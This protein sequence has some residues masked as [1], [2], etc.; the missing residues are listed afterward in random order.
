[1][2]KVLSFVGTGDYDTVTYIYAQAGREYRTKLFPIAVCEFFQPDEFLVLITDQAQQKYGGI[3][4]AEMQRRQNVRY[5][6]VPIPEGKSEEEV[7]RLFDALTAHFQEG[8]TVVLDV[9]HGFRSLPVLTVI[10]AAYLR[11]AKGVQIEKMVYGAY[12]ARQNDRA[13]VFDLTPFLTLLDWTTATDQFLRTGNATQLTSLLAATQDFLYRSATTDQKLPRRL[14]AVAAT[15]QHLTEAL[16]VARP[17]EA[18]ESA[19]S[20]VTELRNVRPEA[21]QWAKPF[22]VLLERTRREYERFALPKSRTDSRANLR[23]QRDLLRWYIDKGQIVEAIILAREWLV[24]LTAYRL[25]REQIAER[26][27][28]EDLLNKAAKSL[29][30]KNQ[31]AMPGE[32]AALPECNQLVEVWDRVSDLRNDVAHL[33]VRKQ[34][35]RTKTIIAEVQ[36]LPEQ[37]SA[38]APHLAEDG[39]ST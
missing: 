36:K 31:S 11:V 29:R 24:S 35:R 22:G 18:V 32:L 28:V 9:T 5:T 16:R 6:P 15:I 2:K 1:M 14:K 23:V 10:A 3:L 20:M 26:P 13:P 34:P 25:G 33:G 7:W 19:V 37:L 4:S 30:P 27:A 39:A 38:L 12:D 8:D 21:E 17:Q